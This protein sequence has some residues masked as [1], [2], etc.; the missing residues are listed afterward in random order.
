MIIDVHAHVYLRE[1]SQNVRDIV[2]ACNLYGVSRVYISTIST[3][4]Y[5]TEDEVAKSNET[6]YEIMKEHPDLISGYCY[7]N[8]RHEKSLD[9]LKKGIEDYGMSGMKL[10]VDAFCDDPVVFPL[11]EQCI[12]YGVPIL[13]HS[14][15]KAVGQGKEESVGTNVANL[16]CRYPEAK[17]I[18]AHLG[19]NC[20][21]GIR[22]IRDCANVWTDHS[23]SIFRRDD[24]D[25]AKEQLGA[26]R[27]LFGTDLPDYMLDNIGQVEE[28]D[29]TPEE[30]ELVF[31]K[32]ALKVFDRHFRPKRRRVCMP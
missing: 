22:A 28:A 14:F 30:R 13:V 11:V 17:I 2:K 16:A 18:M 25:Y 12:D 24:L 6:T 26:E 10:L 32:N 29:F 20:Y 21:H 5:P 7:I 4:P 23:G 31:Y 1:Y 9:F 8:P 3:M 19:G 15:I 27:I